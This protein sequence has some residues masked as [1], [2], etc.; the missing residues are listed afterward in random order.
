MDIDP[1]AE[2]S[3]DFDNI[4]PQIDRVQMVII[5]DIEANEHLCAEVAKFCQQSAARVNLATELGLHN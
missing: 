1:H 2:T 3:G 5:K 4:R